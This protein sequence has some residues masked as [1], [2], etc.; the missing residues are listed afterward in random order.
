MCPLDDA[1]EQLDATG[2][3]EETEARHM[4]V[5][6]KPTPEEVAAHEET[7]LPSRSWCK[8]CVRGR[9]RS[10]S[11]HRVSGKEEEQIPTISVDYGFL[12]TKDTPATELPV[13]VGRDRQ[14]MAVWA[15]PVPHKGA[16][17]SDHGVDRLREWLNET[18]YQR[19]IVKSDQEP[20]IKA[21]I[22]AVKTSCRTR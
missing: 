6:I 16:A 18:G 17:E 10:V 4:R 5:A 1:A 14:S 20:A 21:V 12:G 9:G 3:D 19:V 8:Y 13:L 15:S 2:F 7:H 22:N 11:H